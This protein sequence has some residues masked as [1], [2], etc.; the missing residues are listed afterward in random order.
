[1]KERHVDM[2][3]EGKRTKTKESQARKRK[4]GNWRVM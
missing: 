1:M 2:K 4:K 3:E